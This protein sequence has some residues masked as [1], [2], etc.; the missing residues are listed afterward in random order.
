MFTLKC[1]FGAYISEF[2]GRVNFIS[3]LLRIIQNSL[4]YLQQILQNEEAEAASLNQLLLM[5]D[6]LS[7][8]KGV[9]EILSLV[10]KLGRLKLQRR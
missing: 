8:E 1:L 2:F 5:V 3:Y 7:T 10:F 4:L 6:F 9:I